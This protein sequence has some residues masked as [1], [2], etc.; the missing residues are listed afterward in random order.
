[1]LHVSSILEHHINV[2]SD[3]LIIVIPNTRGFP[4][5]FILAICFA[6]LIIAS[7]LISKFLVQRVTF[8]IMSA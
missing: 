7:C 8:L 3:F 6:Q 4:I 5:W 2:R 1:M